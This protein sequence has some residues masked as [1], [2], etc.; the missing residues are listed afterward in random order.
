M[1]E[2]SGADHWRALAAREREMAD[3]DQKVRGDSPAAHLARAET[4]EKTAKSIEMTEET[5]VFHCACCLKPIS[6]LGATR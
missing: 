3:W 5:G 4:F 1:S 6:K 2:K